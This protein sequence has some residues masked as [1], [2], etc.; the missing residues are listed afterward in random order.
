[1]GAAIEY[2]FTVTGGSLLIDAA[3]DG[4][5]TPDPITVGVQGSFNAIINDGENHIGVSDT[6][7]LSSAAISNADTV[8]ISLLG[9]ATATINPGS[10][11]F[12]GFHEPGNIGSPTLPVHIADAGPGLGEATVIGDVTVDAY[13]IV[14]GLIETNLIT[15]TNAGEALAFPITITTSADASETVTLNL[16]ATF[17][18][19]I[20]VSDISNTIT[21]DLIIDISGTAHV[22]PDPAFGGLTALGL[23][24]AGA[25]LRRRRA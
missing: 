5:A 19:E 20:G 9:L 3:P 23:A 22:V 14:T 8:A 16:G 24:G 1:M 11:V 2:T 17:V 7:A 21:L 12:T 6:I 25:W 4:L 13:V 15:S 18:Y 10:A